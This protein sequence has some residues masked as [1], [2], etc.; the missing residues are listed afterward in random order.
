[1]PY[2]QGYVTA[3]LVYLLFIL[4]TTRRIKCYGSWE[5][6]CKWQNHSFALNKFLLRSIISNVTNS[7]NELLNNC[8]ANEFFLNQSIHKNMQSGVSIL[9]TFVQF[10]CFTQFVAVPTARILL[11]FAAQLLNPFTAKCGQRQN[12]TKNPKFHS[13]KFWKTSST[14]WKYKQKGFIW[15]VT[16]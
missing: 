2:L 13:A 16:T 10:S 8:M 5:T 15:M 3:C 4:P 1:M 7:K 14:M 6:T 9:S 12:S 11:N